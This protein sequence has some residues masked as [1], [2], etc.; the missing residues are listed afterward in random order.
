MNASSRNEVESVFDVT[1]PPGPYPGLRP[2]GKDEWSIFFGRERMTDD[3]IRR[4]VDQR[5]LVVH[6]DSGCGK[7]SLISAGVL[8]RLEQEAARG[9]LR[10]LTCWATPGD[11]PLNNLAQALA[12]LGDTTEAEA[13]FL[14][15]RRILNCGRD[16]APALADHIRRAH[17]ES[18][19]CVLLDQF[20]E[21]FAHARRE[22]PQEA[23]L[24][25]DLLVGLQ[26]LAAPHLGVVLTMRS[27]FLGACAQFENFAEVVNATQYLL[28]RM[29]HCDLVRAIREPATLYDGEVSLDLAEKLIA[30]AWGGQDQLPLIQHGLMVLH[31]ERCAAASFGWNL[32]LSDYS[33][34]RGL[35]R[36]LSDHADQVAQQVTQSS[37]RLADSRIVEDI[38]RALIEIN[39]DGQAI[40]RPQRLSKLIAVA[41]G[42]EVAVRAV[43]DEFRV[44]GVSFL[45]PH[46][47]API[48]ADDH[49]DISHEALIRYWQALADP[50]DGWLIQEFKYGL[51]WRS[52]L[53]Q[54]ESFERDASNILSAATTEERETWMKQRNRDWSERY[55][56]G[57]ER[58]TQLIEAS[59]TERERLVRKEAQE[60]KQAED[61]R[62]HKHELQARA[63]RN[64]VFN[65]MLGAVVVVMFFALS[66]RY[67]AHMQNEKAVAALQVARTNYKEAQ[68]AT[69]RAK[70]FAVVIKPELDELRR[71]SAESADTNLKN[72]ID[73]TNS[74]IE[75]QVDQLAQAASLSP[76]I[77]VHIAQK[78]QRDAAGMLAKRLDGRQ[79]GD[80]AIVVPGIQ[81]VSKPPSYALL[82]C[83]REDECRDDGERLVKMIN[84][85]LVTPQVRLQSFMASDETLQN[86]RPRHYELWFADEPIKLEGQH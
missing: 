1:L 60:R 34:E 13:N 27:E 63:S 54:T 5:F 52:L 39:A 42:D 49:I 51:V 21:I 68:A 38:F 25:I 72:S 33:V 44:E 67:E 14:E 7:S 75:Q 65:W 11:E 85:M 31:R 18:Q 48:A 50:H 10:W 86:L 45:R 71:L 46:G 66:Q 58:V 47:I 82:R 4:L 30:D 73:R 81:R 62:L 20:E 56:G 24:L 12:V 8:P 26:K 80:A 15:V 83:F 57:W 74:S 23:T 35:A 16:G 84:Q 22:G 79:L 43:I 9:G 69:E 70:S 41:G 77:Y 53:V 36:L 40:R 6:G 19:V 64:R 59:V 28:P 76:R 2:F 32:T 55:G 17:V 37:V 3:V 78:S 29:A 61:A